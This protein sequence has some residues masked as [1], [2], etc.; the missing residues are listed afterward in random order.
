MLLKLNRLQ[1]EVELSKWEQQME[2]E[3]DELR[4]YVNATRSRNPEA[5]WTCLCC[6]CDFSGLK[7]VL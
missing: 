3:R 2:E 5:S 6:G 4:R 1:E 7:M